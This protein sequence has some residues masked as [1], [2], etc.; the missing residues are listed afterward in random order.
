MAGETMTFTYEGEHTNV[1][2]IVVDWLSD[3]GDGT[4]TGTTKQI[5]GYLLKGV[6]DPDAVAAPDDDYNIVLTDD[7]GANILGN[8]WDDLLLRDTA[9]VES[10][11]FV[12]YDGAGSIAE[13]PCVC[14]P[15]TI[16]IDSAGNAKQG[17]LVLYWIG[18]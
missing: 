2:R 1:R 16:D 9:N 14:D 8:C 4:C 6:T 11:D 13:R 15:I 10:V 17:R 18:G 5:P 3:D 12:L 7:E